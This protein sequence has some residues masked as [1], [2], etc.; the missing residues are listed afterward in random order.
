ME[1]SGV[2]VQA[3]PLSSNSLQLESENQAKPSRPGEV[4]SQFLRALLHSMLGRGCWVND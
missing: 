4:V 1:G 2:A 3:V